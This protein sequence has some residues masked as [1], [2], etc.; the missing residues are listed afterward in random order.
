[1][2]NVEQKL[3]DYYRLMTQ[4]FNDGNF[5]RAMDYFLLQSDS[6]PPI[7]V[8]E[9]KREATEKYRAWETRSNLLGL[10]YYER[11]I[12]GG[13]AIEF[14]QMTQRY[15][16]TPSHQL[17]RVS[18]AL[19]TLDANLGILLGDADPNKIMRR[20]FAGY[21]KRELRRVRKR[22]LRTLASGVTEARMAAGFATDLL[23]QNAITV[24]GIKR[25]VD[26][27]AKSALG[28]LRA[29]LIGVFVVMTYDYVHHHHPKTLDR[30]DARFEFLETVAVRIPGYHQ[31]WALIFMLFSLYLIRQTSRVRRRYSQPAVAL[32]NGRTSFER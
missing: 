31:E 8:A 5:G 6:V 32:P 10:T 25:K 9:F 23:R 18:R 4:A 3:L 28:A 15:K 17:L 11:S 2:G 24:H 7:D 20:Y 19:G 14:A 26:D 16:I 29:V 22:G 30:L 12:T 21:R 1:V 13:I 27:L